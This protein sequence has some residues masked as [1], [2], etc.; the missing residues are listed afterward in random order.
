MGW[1]GI[2]NL[3]PGFDV[4][5]GK[6]E[7]SNL[8]DEVLKGRIPGVTSAQEEMFRDL[9][10]H[11]LHR[12]YARY[13]EL[14]LAC[15]EVFREREQGKFL[16]RVLEDLIVPALTVA[17]EQM[18]SV[19]RD[20]VRYAD[21]HR[22]PEYDPYSSLDQLFRKARPIALTYPAAEGA[23]LLEPRYRAITA[24]IRALPADSSTAGAPPP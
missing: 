15:G 17:L 16:P 4:S 23:A 18:E 10:R 24:E 7:R 5:G 3:P 22:A 8:V 9:K 11:L 1:G 20:M 14:T 19:R 13:F 2:A 21:S 6:G 12:D